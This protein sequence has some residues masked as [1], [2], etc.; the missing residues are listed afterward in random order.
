MKSVQKSS[1]LLLLIAG[2]KGAVGSTV[3]VA[4]SA[5]QK[6]TEKVLPNLTTA[7]MF[8]EVLPANQIFVAGWD[9]SDKSLIDSVLD[10]EVLNEK[11]WTGYKND[12]E[13]IHIQEV[14]ESHLTPKAQVEKL[15]D[16]IRNFK[17]RY[18]GA[19]PVLINLLP[20]CGDVDLSHCNNLS[21]LYDELKS[22]AFPDMMYTIAAVTSGVPVVNFSSNSLEVP[23]IVNEAIKHNVPISGKDGKTGQTYFKMVLASALKARNLLVNGWYSLNILGNQD[24]ENL[25]DPHKA[26]EKLRN[27]V[28]LLNEILGYKVED[29]NGNTTHKV[30][31]DYYPPRGDSKEAYD[32]IDVSGIFGLQ[33]SIRLN[34]LGRDSIL[35]AP[36]VIDLARWMAILQMTGRSGIVPELGFYYKKSV[37]NHPSVTF[38]EEFAQLQK[39]YVECNS[40]LGERL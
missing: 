7:D 4:G 18:I 10:H 40:K 27:K 1:P 8:A 11:I 25:S 19:K 34:L 39:L 26:S 24:G 21:D 6:D 2:A 9:S 20:A 15:Q 14:P 35:A 38:Q 17:K 36:L 3:A 28:D 29:K 13:Q 16:D 31:I 23:V 32:V 5:L 37:S 30:H 12:L 33:M 22:V